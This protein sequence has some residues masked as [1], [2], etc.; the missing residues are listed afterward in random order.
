MVAVEKRRVSRATTDGARTSPFKHTHNRRPPYMEQV[1]DERPRCRRYPVCVQAQRVIRVGSGGKDAE[2]HS[3]PRMAT[4][5]H[6]AACL[7][8]ALPLRQQ[9]R[10]VVL[11]ELFA[12]GRGQGRAGAGEGVEAHTALCQAPS[13]GR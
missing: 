7:L 3:T 10:L 8:D 12:V 6:C 4:H 1:W 9:Y 13:P 5:L 2:L 11:G